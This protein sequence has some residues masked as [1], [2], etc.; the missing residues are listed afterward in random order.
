MVAREIV[1]RVNALMSEG[2][3][4][5]ADKLVP[6]ALLKEDL[7]LDSLDAVDMLVILEERLKTKIE[8]IRIAKVKTMGDIYE[9]VEEAT[10][11]SREKDNSEVRDL[12]T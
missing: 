5:T 1:D 12:A 6:G 3:E 2:F 10:A 11:Q 9:L 8:G 7:G 4:I